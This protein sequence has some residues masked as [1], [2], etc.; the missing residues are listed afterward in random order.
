MGRLRRR[1]IGVMGG[2]FDPIHTG[3]LVTAEEALHQFGLDEVLF[4]PSGHP[5]HKEDRESLDPESRYLMAVI[6]TADNPRFRVLRMELERPGPSY[7]IDTVRELRR[8]YGPGTDI[9]FITGAD[10]ILEILT[11]K[12]PEKLLREARFIAATRP[13]YDLKRLEDALPEAEKERHAEDPR[14]LVME[15]PALAI[16]ST[17]IRERV[18]EGRP[19]T[20]LV[21]KGVREFIEK[22]GF[23]R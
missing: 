20:Y 7:T 6:A 11:W 3:H 12:D 8:L 5:P 19:V 9:F 18:R 21:P 17:D 1:R 14:V 22:N 10:A 23:Y 4:I 2:T 15:I 13:G 16:S